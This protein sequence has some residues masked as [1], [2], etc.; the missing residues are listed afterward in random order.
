MQPS[1][2]PFPEGS[3]HAKHWRSSIRDIGRILKVTLVSQQRTEPGHRDQDGALCT[4]GHLLTSETHPKE[5]HTNDIQSEHTGVLE[6][7]GTPLASM[8]VPAPQAPAM[9]YMPLERICHH[10]P[11]HPYGVQGLLE[12]GPLL[13]DFR[14]GQERHRACHA[15]RQQQRRDGSND[16][17][18]PSCAL[19]M[20]R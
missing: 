17:A 19:P 1:L 3:H 14:D 10:L 18:H 13:L 2:W 16:N 7:L 8:I 15:P 6:R 4:T 20:M 12:R 9:A 11:V 5:G